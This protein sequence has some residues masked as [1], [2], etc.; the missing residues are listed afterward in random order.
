M[1]ETDALPRLA[2]HPEDPMTI[3]PSRRLFAAAAGALAL[4]SVPLGLAWAGGPRGDGP[5]GPPTAESVR[6]RMQIVEDRALERV[7]ATADQR[8]KVDAILDDA[9]PRIAEHRKAAHDLKKQFR[10]A[11][12]APDVDRKQLERLRRDM[13]DLADQSSDDLVDMAADLA[14]VLSP[15]QRAMIGEALKHRDE[16][17]GRPPR[18]GGFDDDLDGPPGE[19][20]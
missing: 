9:A 17:G 12:M 3:A 5:H 20:L 4:I 19:G 16:A 18:G 13:L 8:A 14:E 15:E 2:S 6:A 11:L 10:E 1:V 7:G